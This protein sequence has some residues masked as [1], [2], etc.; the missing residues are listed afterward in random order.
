MNYRIA[1]DLYSTRHFLG[2]YKGYDISIEWQGPEEPDEYD[3]GFEEEF[4]E[5]KDGQAYYIRVT[6][7]RG[8]AYDGYW[9]NADHTLEM[10]IEEALRG[11]CLISREQASF[12]ELWKDAA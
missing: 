2:R 1:N 11:S 4:E 9:G 12:P 5:P 7:D 3:D 6:S 10:A 8:T